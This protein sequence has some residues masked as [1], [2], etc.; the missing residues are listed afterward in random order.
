MVTNCNSQGMKKS[1]KR[2]N[3]TQLTESHAPLKLGSV[4]ISQKKKKNNKMHLKSKCHWDKYF[5]EQLKNGASET[6]RFF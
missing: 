4:H 1:K 2:L 6:F 5:Y 3:R